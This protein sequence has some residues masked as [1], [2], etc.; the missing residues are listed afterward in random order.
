MTAVAVDTGPHLA[1]PVTD[2][3]PP[4]TDHR[5]PAPPAQPPWI[6]S[7]VLSVAHHWHLRETAA[8]QVELI[9]RHFRQ[10]EMLAAL[11]ELET[12]A[13]TGRVQKRQGGA[14]KSA[15]WA[16]AMDIV[17]IL[18]QLGDRNEL[19]RFLIQ[20]DDLRRVA[21][22]LGA[23]SVS[24]ERGVAARL[25]A[26][27]LS[28]RQGME[29]MKRMVK[30]AMTAVAVADTM[31]VVEVT[32]PTSPSFAEVARSQGAQGQVQL[33][34]GAQAQGQLGRGAQAQGLHGRD[35]GPSNLLNGR[36]EEGHRPRRQDRSSS[37][38]KRRRTGDP[39][40][41]EWQEQRH[42]RGGGGGG[43]GRQQRPRPSVIKGTSDQFAELAG[44]ALFW[45]GKCR[46]DMDDGK[47]KEIIM[48]CAESCEVEGFE[49]ESVKCLTTAP[50]P[51][52]KSFKVAVP[53]KFE[54]AMMNPKMYPPSWEARPF[55]R[56][57]SRRVEAADERVEAGAEV[58]DPQA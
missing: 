53:A 52:S 25:E 24:D 43:G 27:E 49:I 36:Q 42:R 58:A 9:E 35:A 54:E 2:T 45:V 22:L 50:N 37:A 10:D 16:Q 32:P 44:P 41:G 3:G 11:R 14:G 6:E 46:T 7:L 20:S 29:E 56:W 21:P 57:P 13:N 34:R 40:D 5:P 19:P 38:S 26:L 12:V 31:P 48:N 18:K 17:N 33:G 23:V 1:P 47:I 51:W 30:A 39:E 28:Q 8:R 15:S 55:T 4:A